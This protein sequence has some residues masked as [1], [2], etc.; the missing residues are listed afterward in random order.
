MGGKKKKDK[1][2]SGEAKEQESSSVEEEL[3]T[4]RKQITDLLASQGKLQT[5]VGDLLEQLKAQHV[6]ST[7]SP[8]LLYTSPRQRA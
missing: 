5:Q 8:C 2:K 1:K 6:G 3:K 7:T 4:A